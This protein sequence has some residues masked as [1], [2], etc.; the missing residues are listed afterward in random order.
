M[1]TVAN[2]GELVSLH[3]MQ[4]VASSILVS[5]T[6]VPL[7][8]LHGVMAS[9]RPDLL[10]P[11][12]LRRRRGQLGE[13]WRDARPDVDAAGVDRPHRVRHSNHASPTMAKLRWGGPAD[14][15]D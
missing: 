14:R 3:G 9:S 15:V 7:S 1:W 5:S 4:E 6:P 12:R 13:W 10:A 2:P 8:G 11:L